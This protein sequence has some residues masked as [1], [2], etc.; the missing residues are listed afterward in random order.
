MACIVFIREL[1]ASQ[2]KF[3]R[4]YADGIDGCGLGMEANV[5]SSYYGLLRHLV[6]LI[7]KDM[8]SSSDRFF[9]LKSI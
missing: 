7:R 8:T 9:I 6:T 5:R 2:D 1:L 3:G 4:H